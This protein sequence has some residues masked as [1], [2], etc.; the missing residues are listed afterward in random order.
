[1]TKT[2]PRDRGGATDPHCLLM[3]HS[4]QYELQCFVNKYSLVNLRWFALL[5]F[6]DVRMVAKT[7]YRLNFHLICSPGDARSCGLFRRRLASSY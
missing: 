5:H 7:G 3:L 6:W 2:L 1:M 4:Y